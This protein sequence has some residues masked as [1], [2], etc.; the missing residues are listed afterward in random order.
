VTSLVG[1]AEQ[2]RVELVHVVA[3]FGADVTLPRVG[4]GVAAL[5]QKVESLVG[6]EDAAE[7]AEVR[8]AR[9][10]RRQAGVAAAAGRPALLQQGAQA[11]G[12]RGGRCG[13]AR[14]VREVPRL[15]AATPCRQIKRPSEVSDR[16]R[17]SIG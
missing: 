6:E 8:A 12:A 4:L 17:G 2:V 14:G 5:V 11:R 9:E 7:V 10:E 3:H 16:E 13:A 15:L 1:L